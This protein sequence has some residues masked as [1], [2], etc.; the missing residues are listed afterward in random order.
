[1]NMMSRISQ[2]NRKKEKEIIPVIMKEAISPLA[3][4]I[5]IRTSSMGHRLREHFLYRDTARFTAHRSYLL[6]FMS[7]RFMLVLSMC[8]IGLDPHL[9]RGG[10]TV[11][12]QV[13]L[14]IA[15]TTEPLLTSRSEG[16]APLMQDAVTPRA[17]LRSQDLL[18]DNVDNGEGKKKTDVVSI[19]TRRPARPLKESSHP[20]S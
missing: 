8:A 14:L 4:S 9:K 3:H 2:K 7:S 6:E 1:M 12:L 5:T 13:S 17:C 19:S 15:P 18:A 10:E 11:K 16:V 20:G